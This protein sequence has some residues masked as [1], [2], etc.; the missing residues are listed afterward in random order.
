MSSIALA[1]VY[2]RSFESYPHVTLAVAGGALTALG[3]VVAQFSQI[4]TSEDDHRRGFQYDVPRT[5]RFFCFGAGI[6]P[7]IGRWNK[8][9]ELKFPLRSRRGGASSFTQLSKRVLV[10]QVFMAPI[11]LSVFLS[12]MAV[13][14]GRGLEHIRGRFKD[15]Y[16][17]VLLANWKVWPAAQ[18]INFRF[19]PLPYR[20]PFQQTC[21]VFW[22]LYLSLLNSAESRKQDEEDTLRRAFEQKPEI[23]KPASST[24]TA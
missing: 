13:M 16:Q 6:S 12:S 18:F 15:I 5:V 17:P 23:P 11:G 3:D 7:L 24:L 4:I 2:R 1:Q 10:D 9:L 21:G 14:E 20:V 8:Y 22:T 19:I